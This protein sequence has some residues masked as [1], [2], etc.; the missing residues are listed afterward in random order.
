MGPGCAAHQLASPLCLALSF[1]HKC[2]LTT[3][4]IMSICHGPRTLEKNVQGGKKDRLQAQHKANGGPE[5][6]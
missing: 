5:L 1:T 3:K 4:R 2:P 6:P